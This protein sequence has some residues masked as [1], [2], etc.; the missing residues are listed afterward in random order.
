MGFASSQLS[1]LADR[2]GNLALF[3]IV[4]GWE[5]VML[6]IKYVMQTSISKLPQCVEDEMKREQF[7]ETM[8]VNTAM[9]SKSGRRSQFAR[10]SRLSNG[11][12]SR[13]SVASHQGSVGT[14]QHQEKDPIDDPNRGGGLRAIPSG[15]E[16]DG[17]TLYSLH[18]Q[19]PS[20]ETA[21]SAVPEETTSEHKS[22][23]G[24]G[25]EVPTPCRLEMGSERTGEA[26]SRVSSPFE[27]YVPSQSFESPSIA[28]SPRRMPDSGNLSGLL[29]KTLD[30]DVSLDTPVG[31][32]A[33][34]TDQCTTEEDNAAAA[35]RIQTRL[36][37]LE[38]RLHRLP[39]NS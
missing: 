20:V 4:V 8:R 30:D 6:L 39:K 2:I 11:D 27:M 5:H 17:S 13:L 36:M 1:N 23:P 35:E 29:G 3:C 32:F 12:Q 14:E 33:Q 22:A 16:T 9:R 19:R 21:V 26:V 25:I 31:S 37:R 18:H 15:D 7:K 34:R 10:S 24:S 28:A 38:K